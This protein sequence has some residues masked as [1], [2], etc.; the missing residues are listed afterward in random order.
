MHNIEID[1]RTIMLFCEI[2]Y[3]EFIKRYTGVTLFSLQLCPQ[4]D[5]KMAKFLN[6]NDF[7]T[8]SG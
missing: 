1:Y 6:L 2:M 8:K 7:I 5:V 4:N 3:C